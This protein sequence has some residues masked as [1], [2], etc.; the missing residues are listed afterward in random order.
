[1]AVILPDAPLVTTSPEV[2]RLHRLLKQLPDE[3]YTVWH[4]LTIHSEPG[5]DFW[6]LHR[7][8]RALWIKVST[9]TPLQAKVFTQPNLFGSP[10]SRPAEA[11]HRALAQFARLS[12]STTQT[13]PLQRLP[14]VV[15][16]PNLA[17]AELARLTEVAEIPPAVSWVA[18]EHLAPA[19]FSSWLQD[20]LTVLLAEDDI[21]RLRQAFTPEVVIPAHFT[22]RAAPSGT[23]ANRSLREPIQRYTAA[24]VTPYLLD[25]D[26]ERVLKTELDLSDEARATVTDFNLRLVNG[27]AGSG[28]SLIVV[29]RAQLLRRLFPQRSVL[30]LTHNRP[31]INDLQARYLALNPNDAQLEWLTFNQWCRRLWPSGRPFKEPIG[32]ESKRRLITSLWHRHLADTSISEQMLQDEIDWCKDR[33]IFSRADYLATDRTGRGFALSEAQRDRMYTA[34]EAYQAYLNRR[35]RMDWGDVP[36]QI[37]RWAQ[38][39]QL[40]LPQHDVILVDEAQFFAP[41]WFELIKRAVKPRT[42]HLFLVADPTQGFLKRRQSWLASGLEVR[43]RVHRLKKSYR[44]TREILD[45]ATLLYRTRVP[46]DDD[47]IETPDLLEMPGGVFPQII[48]LTSEQDEI[49]R[50]VNEIEQLVRQGVPQRH[51]LVIHTDWRGRDRLLER[52]RAKFGLLAAIDPK[53]APPGDV[54]RVCTL[55]AVTGLESPI[56]FLVG[57]HHLFEQEQ[58]VRL[59]DEERA[60]LIRDN[61]RRLYMALTRAGQRVVITYVGDL[62]DAMSARSPDPASGAS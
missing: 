14:A 13:Q 48:P 26:Q 16:F 15:A 57:V 49:T 50:V 42:G 45:F 6:V 11:E 47:D 62:P 29:Y 23:S 21:A 55:N 46:N 61:T 36:R 58:S 54:I 28:K 20:R 34:F 17:E 27:V 5:P 4:R 2:A 35:G 37:W 38:A 10:V 9:L 41:I 25:Y 8:R 60:E 30:G 44:T 53:D 7:D 18:K 24:G 52:L 39:G 51:L 40:R 33:L 56:V 1:M 43:G 19:A 59:S 12:F 32:I 3:T 31:L 22:V